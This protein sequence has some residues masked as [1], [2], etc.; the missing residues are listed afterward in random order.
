LSSHQRTRLFSSRD[1]TRSSSRFRR[2]H[3]VGVF[4]VRECMQ[5]A[6]GVL[7]IC[8]F[9]ELTVWGRSSPTTVLHSSFGVPITFPCHWA[10]DTPCTLQNPLNR[11]P[12]L[13]SRS[14][15]TFTPATY[16]APTNPDGDAIPALFGL[17][18]QGGGSHHFSRS[19]GRL[20]CDLLGVLGRMSSKIMQDRGSS[21]AFPAGAVQHLR[22]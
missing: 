19:P 13:A 14:P 7:M 10:T 1:G 8:R 16:K 17:H 6:L 11:D 20:S 2:Q 9:N 5:R 22:R 18:F 4:F 12:R 21:S 3:G 15:Y